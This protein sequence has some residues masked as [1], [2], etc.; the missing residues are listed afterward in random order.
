MGTE[1]FLKLVLPDEGKKVLALATPTEDGKRVWF[2]YKTYTSVEQIAEAAVELDSRGETVFFA[3]NSFGNWYLDEKKNKKRLRTQENVVSCRSIY[4]DFDVGSEDDKKYTSRDEALADVIK[5]AK[6]LQLTPTITSSGG[7][8]H[9]YFSLDEDVSKEVWTELSMLKRDVT[10][11]LKLKADRAVDM[12]SARILRPVGTHN[13]KNETPR[14]VELVKLGKA[15]PVEVVRSKLMGYIKEHDVEPAPAPQPK[16]DNDSPFGKFGDFPPADAAQIAEHCLEIR[17]FKD[18]QGNI[19]EPHWHRAI[20]VLKH[21]KDGEQVI[22]DWSKG[23][24]GYTAGETQN[25]IDEWS[26]GPTSCAEMDK[27]V[28][29]MADCQMADKCRYPIQ[30]GNTEEAESEGEE[31]TPVV[32]NPAASSVV[33]EGQKLP[34]W[35]TSGFRWNGTML[36]RA[37]TDE[38]GVVH[39]RPFCRS[40][41]YPLNRIQDSEGT[42]VIHWKAKEKNGKW[43]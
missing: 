29:C 2:K 31:T 19:S 18:S 36:S 17:E 38:D 27:H 37:I 9:C 25:K 11:H 12:D 15:Y 24:A 7:G 4:D 21:C 10:N 41:I 16:S 28:G 5:L 3:V 42:W 1:Q 40:F 23:Y 43:R 30:L 13:R 22:H 35:P 32:Q 34:Y 6:A 14:E 39:W 33:I 20:G 8:Y 26:V